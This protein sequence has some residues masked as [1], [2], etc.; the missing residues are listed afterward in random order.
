MQRP[1]SFSTESFASA[2]FLWWQVK[3]AATPTAF[4]LVRKWGKRNGPAD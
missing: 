2:D 4:H 1:S 3:E